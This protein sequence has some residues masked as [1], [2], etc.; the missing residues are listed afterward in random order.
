MR[1]REKFQFF[2]ATFFPESHGGEDGGVKRSEGAA[3]LVVLD[4]FESIGG[5]EGKKQADRGG[6]VRRDGPEH[7][8][9]VEPGPWPRFSGQILDRDQNR[10]RRNHGRGRHGGQ[11]HA[12]PGHQKGGQKQAQS[13]GDDDRSDSGAVHAFVCSG[14][15]ALGEGEAD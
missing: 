10:Q 5:I 4:W 8:R 14:D 6:S 11:K 12:G 13:G 2:P 1:K 7:E 3:Q 15:R 9:E